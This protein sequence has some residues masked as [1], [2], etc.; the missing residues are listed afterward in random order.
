MD[1]KTILKNH[2]QQKW[3]NIYKV[4]VQCLQYGQV[5]VQ[6]MSLMYTGVKIA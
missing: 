3:V 1:A 2:P 5:M 4:V 6:K